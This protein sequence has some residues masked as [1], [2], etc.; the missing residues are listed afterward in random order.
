MFYF[1]DDEKQKLRSFR[2]NERRKAMAIYGRRRAGKTELVLD[3]IAKEKNTDCLYYQYTSFDYNTCLQDYLS[4]VKMKYPDDPILDSLQSFRDV[5]VYLEKAYDH[6]LLVFIDEFPFLCRKNENAVIEFQWIIDHGLHR[7]KLVLLGSNL[8]CM[9]QQINDMVAPLYGRFDEIMEIQPFTFSEVH[10]LFPAFADA[11]EVYAMT[12]GV[13][14]YVM[15]FKEYRSVASAADTLFFDKNGRLLQEASNLLMQEVRDITTYAAILRTIAGG[16]KD[17]GQ[18]AAEC[19]MDSRGVFSYLNKLID[20]GILTTVPNSLSAK[21]REKRF[22]IADMLFRFHYTFLEPN[23]SAITALGPR[24]RKHILDNRYSEYLGF[25]YE[26]IIRGSCFELAA[27]GTLP[28]MPLTVGKWWGNV[29]EEGVWH[30]SE[31]DLIAYDDRNI[32]I[33]ECKYR[34]KKVGLTELNALRAKA[35]F[36]SVKN[37]RIYYLL[38]SKSGFTPSLMERAD[39]DVVLIHEDKVL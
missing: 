22:K 1:R 10:Q 31:L 15:F 7:Q 20:L 2:D 33:G 25:V 5:F 24:S 19:G 23:M 16:E 14:Q 17:S 21:K 3:F 4:V 34:N 6:Q 28:F 37:R 29:S 36:V 27:A 12:G 11:A 18:I 13:A 39:N 38:A 8:S 9:K 32:I 35:G 30:E 26:D